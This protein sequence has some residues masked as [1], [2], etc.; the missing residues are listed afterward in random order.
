MH[1][2]LPTYKTLLN[3]VKKMFTA[4]AV[5]LPQRIKFWTSLP[6]DT[7]KRIVRKRSDYLGHD[8][9]KLA[10]GTNFECDELQFST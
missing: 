7:P 9:V 4:E 10:V 3:V 8:T 2:R 5:F 1:R 6:E